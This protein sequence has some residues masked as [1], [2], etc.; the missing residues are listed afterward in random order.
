[1]GYFVSNLHTE[2]YLNKNYTTLYS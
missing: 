2:K 1:M